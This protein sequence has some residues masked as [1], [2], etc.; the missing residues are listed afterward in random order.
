MG[1]GGSFLEGKAAGGVKLIAQ[2]H[3]VPRSRML[4][5]YFYSPIRLPGVVL[6]KHTDNS[7]YARGAQNRSIYEAALKWSQLSERN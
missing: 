3:L 7:A 6:I 1:T 2:L 5:L 4:E